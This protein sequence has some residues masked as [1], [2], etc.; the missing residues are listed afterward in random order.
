[1]IEVTIGQCLHDIEIIAKAG[2]AEDVENQI[3]YLPV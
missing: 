1:L 3:T 2:E